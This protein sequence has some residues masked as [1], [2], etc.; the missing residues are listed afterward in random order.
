MNAIVLLLLSLLFVLVLVR[1]VQRWDQTRDAWH[2]WCSVERA[3]RDHYD[4]PFPQ[5]LKR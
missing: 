4:E 3:W 5:D 1:W 2:L